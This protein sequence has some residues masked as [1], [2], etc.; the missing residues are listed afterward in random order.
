MM[1]GLNPSRS[2]PENDPQG[3][4][5]SRIDGYSGIEV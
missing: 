5:I 3:T 2:F 1:E 4:E